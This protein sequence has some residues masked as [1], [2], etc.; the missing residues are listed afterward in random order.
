MSGRLKSLLVAVFS[1]LALL[2]STSA[3][4]QRENTNNDDKYE[5]EE[6]KR[7]SLLE[8]SSIAQLIRN[9]FRFYKKRKISGKNDKKRLIDLM[10]KSRI[11]IGTSTVALAHAGRK[12]E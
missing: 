9:S 4:A 5:Y 8:K 6:L 12:Y 10:L 2:F 11:K 3:L 1:V 7:M